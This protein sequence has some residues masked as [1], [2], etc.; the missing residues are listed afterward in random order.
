VLNER[1]VPFMR[2]EILP[3]YARTAHTLEQRVRAHRFKR[4]NP[5]IWDGMGDHIEALHRD[6]RLQA[7]HLKWAADEIASGNTPAPKPAAESGVTPSPSGTPY[8]AQTLT[9]LA[10]RGGPVRLRR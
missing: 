10:P 1:G 2:L 8:A 7:R 6:V 9:G 4:A 3:P 5:G